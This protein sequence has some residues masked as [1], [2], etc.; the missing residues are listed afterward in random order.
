MTL[1]LLFSIT[2]S[3]CYVMIRFARRLV[4]HILQQDQ[5][6]AVRIPTK[7]AHTS[8]CQPI[9][10]RHALLTNV[11]ETIAGLKL[12]LEQSGDVVVENMFHYGWNYGHYVTIVLAFAPNGGIF[13]C[14]IKA[15]FTMQKS[16]NSE[17]RCMYGKLNELYS[18]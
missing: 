10:L 16:T 14:A 1:R 6:A 9:A 8:F 15:S 11:Y 5:A 4:L 18:I 2:S 17:M 7:E 12:H 13:A 3:S